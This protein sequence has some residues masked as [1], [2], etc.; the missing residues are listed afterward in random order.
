MHKH[1]QKVVIKNIAVELTKQSKQL[2]V[3]LKTK[4]AIALC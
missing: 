2:S 3:P 1:Y 4:M